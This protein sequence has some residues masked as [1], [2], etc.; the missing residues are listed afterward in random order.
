MTRIIKL[1]LVATLC[2]ISVADITAQYNPALNCIESSSSTADNPMCA[3]NVI[4]SAVPFLR[5]APDA[6][7]GALGDSGL[8]TSADPNALHFNSSKLAFVEKDAS[9]SATY[10]PWLRNLGLRDVYLAYLTGYKKVD[11]LQT[12]SL[13]HI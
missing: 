8:A 12:L 1:Y 4:L 3:P 9:F 2:I 13:I 7:S 6:R 11:E 10:T 5:V